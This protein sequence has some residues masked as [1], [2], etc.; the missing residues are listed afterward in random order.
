VS[1]STPRPPRP[2]GAGKRPASKAT[3]SRRAGSRKGA[4]GGAAKQP[5][6]RKELLRK[7]VKYGLIAGLVGTLLLVSIFYFAYRNTKIPDPNTAFQAQTTNVYYA[8]GKEKLGRFATQNRESIKLSEIPKVMQDAVIAAEDRTFWTNKGIDPKGILRAA[9]SN[10]KGNSTQGASTITQQYVKILYLSQER[11]FKRKIKEAFLSL[12]IQQQQS[13]SQILEGYLNTIYFGRGSYGVQAAANAYFG[14]PAKNLNAAQSAM[15]AAIVN[16]PNYLSPDRSADARQALTQRYDYVVSGMVSAGNL[17]AATADRI[18]DKLPK[19]K[20][21]VTSNT[22]GGQTG[23]MLDMVK[24][25]LLEHGFTDAE[26]QGGGLKVTTTFTQKAMDAA[27]AGVEE[28]RPTGKPQLHAAAATVDTKTGALLGFYGGQDYLKSQFNWAAAGNAPGSSFKPFALAAGLK[29]G[30]TLRDTFQGSSP[31]VLPNGDTIKNEG[32]GDGHSYGSS[33]DLIKATQ[34]SVNTAYV[35]LTESIPNGPQ[36][37]KDTAIAMGIPA[38][39]PGLV[40]VPSIALGSVSVSPITMAN[41]Y[42]TIADGG[43]QHDSYVVSKVTRAS[44]GEVLYQAPKSSKR[45]ISED[46]ASNVSYALQQVVKGGTG[47]AAQAINR[48]AAGKTGTATRSDGQVISSW[49]VGFTPQEATAV[50]YVRGT[51]RKSLEGY[52]DPFYGATYPA[53][54]WAAIMSRDMQGVPVVQFPP[55]ATLTGNAPDSGHAPA[56]THQAKPSRPTRTRT[57]TSSPSAPATSSHPTSSPSQPGGGGTTS[58]CV[59]NGCPPTPTSTPTPT[60]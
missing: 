36:K 53:H 38:N 8:D 24:N 42:S 16:S 57:I 17:D 37:V 33:I 23:F 47:I 51:G 21:P 20:K 41:A 5:L 32:Q 28:Q 40:A 26:I 2:G 34:E 4:A 27:K 48:P 15:L 55:A 3:T 59:G 1:S 35:D 14:I 49:F 30:F 58:P 22:L 25:E 19:L 56:P 46:I 18:R 54:T 39:T 6:T 13:K 60:P 29:A 44:D 52:L 9:F 43:L 10:A 50:M 11:T 7:I 45:A 31:Y 12:K